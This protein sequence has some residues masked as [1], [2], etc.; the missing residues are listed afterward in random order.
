MVSTVSELADGIVLRNATIYIAAWQA[1]QILKGSMYVTGSK[2]TVSVGGRVNTGYR[3]GD[4]SERAK[5]RRRS[6]AK[7][8]PAGI[9]GCKTDARTDKD[10][11]TGETRGNRGDPSA[12]LEIY[13]LHQ[14]AGLGSLG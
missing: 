10:V 9:R 8:D 13:A 11:G 12:A 3:H 4:R 2:Y 1:Q 14:S 7:K 6:L 5:S